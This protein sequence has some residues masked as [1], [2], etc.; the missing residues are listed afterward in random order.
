M[1]ATDRLCFLVTVYCLFHCILQQSVT[2][3][4]EKKNK[5]SFY[6]FYQFKPTTSEQKIVLI[7]W[8]GKNLSLLFSK[9][10]CVDLKR[11]DF[12]KLFLG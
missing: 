8:Y 2:T 6:M 5:Q 9:K 10:L 7:Q 11:T 1:G 3:E 4:F 12:H